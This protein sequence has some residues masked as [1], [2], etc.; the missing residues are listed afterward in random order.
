MSWI[1]IISSEL[2][3]VSYKKSQVT[4]KLGFD[5]DEKKPQVKCF[6]GIYGGLQGPQE[7]LTKITWGVTK[8]SF[9]ALLKN[10]ILKKCFAVLEQNFYN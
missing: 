8:I 5:N 10:Y 9:K 6:C 4:L 2:V 7:E 1:I 3:S